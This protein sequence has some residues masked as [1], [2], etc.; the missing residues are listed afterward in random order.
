MATYL[1][2]GGAGFIGSNLVE[3][4]IRRDEKVRVIDNFFTGKKE[5]IE[6]FIPKIELVQGD[7]RNLDGVKE[8]VDGV[9]FVLHEA[10]LTSVVR[11]IERP[12]ATTET[13]IDGTLNVLVAARDAK[14]KRVIYASSSSI[15]GNSPTLLKREDIIPS[16][17][18]P[19]AVSKLSGEYY[20]QVFYR[21]YGLETVILRYFNV[22]GPRQNLVSQYAAAIPRF[23][24][25][26][27]NRKSPTIYG[28]GEQ[29][30]DFTFVEN[31]VEANILAC[32]EE[33]ITGEIF[34][35]G[36]GRSTTINQLAELISRLLDKSI[37]PIYTDPQ[38]GDVRHSLADITKARRLLSY[39]PRI[40]LKE[41]LKRTLKWYRECLS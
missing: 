24:K 17:L 13:N 39:Q 4:L 38:P 28:D 36:G 19:Y 14:V 29:S 1:V 35:I 41:G 11:S 15:Y 2:T 21:I 20:C 25:A 9:D 26:M 18:S 3:E 7:I 23:I 12:L 33:K 32:R 27:L 6:E 10:A 16:P 30:R 31:V 22:F 40:N 37:E 8:A 5:N 34:N